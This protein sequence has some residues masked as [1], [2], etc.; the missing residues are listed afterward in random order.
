MNDTMKKIFWLGLLILTALTAYAQKPELRYVQAS[1]LNVIGRVGPVAQPYQRVD[2][3]QFPELTAAESALLRQSAGMAVTFR[4]DSPIITARAKYKKKYN[5]TNSTMIAGAGFDLYIRRDGAWLYAGSQVQKN[6][7]A[8]LTPVT[9]VRQMDTTLKECLLYL[10]LFSEL[11]SREI[12]TEQ[13]STLE[14]ME[15]PF[16]RRIAYFGSSFTHG[17]GTSRAGMAYPSQLERS[18][19]LYFINL[20]VSGNSKLQPVFADILCRTDAEAFVLDGFSNPQAEE[21]EARLF[22]FIDRI[23]AVRPDVPIVF[24]RTVHREGCNF[25]LVKQAHFED[26]I[27]RAARMARLATERYSDVYFLDIPDLTGT[28]HVTSTDGTHPSDLGYWRWA[29]RLQGPLLEILARY[30]I[31]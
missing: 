22:P 18:T 27:A 16:R 13:G 8:D 15:N 2:V 26:R 24:V 1:E 25:D 14:P 10:P 28:D 20:G 21:V 5:G 17:S 11:E 7:A 6:T 4:T 29:E 30:G 3:A 19:G 9:L 12:G 31:E 23:R